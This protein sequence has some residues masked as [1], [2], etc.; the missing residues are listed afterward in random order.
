MSFLSLQTIVNTWQRFYLFFKVYTKGYV[1]NSCLAP[2]LNTDTV[3][4]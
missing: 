1:V 3:K 4:Q 2:P